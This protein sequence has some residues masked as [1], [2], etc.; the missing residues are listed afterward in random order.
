VYDWSETQSW[1]K[2]WKALMIGNIPD[3]GVARLHCKVCYPAS[4]FA[5]GTELVGSMYPWMQWLEKHVTEENDGKILLNTKALSLVKDG[6]RIVGVKA[7]SFNGMIIHVKGVK[8]VILAGS[9]F[10]NNRNM[11]QKYCPYV[12]KKAVAT[13]LPPTD[14]GETIRMAFGA[15]ADI[16]GRNSWVAFSGAIPFYDTQY[17]GKKEPGPWFQYLRQGFLQLTRGGGWLEINSACEE[18]LPDVAKMDYEMHPKAVAAQDGAAAY[19]VFDDN[20]QKEIWNTLPPPL[21]DDRPMTLDDPEYPW[22]DKFKKFAPKNWVDSVNMAI[23]LGGIKKSDTIEGLAVQLGLDP[24]KLSN[25]IRM[26]NEKSATKKKDAFGRLP[27]NIKPIVKKPYYGIKTGSIIGCIYC[28]PRV[29]YKLEVLDKKLDPIPGLYA[30]GLNAGGTNG[31]G[32]NNPTAL[33]SVGLAYTTGWMAGDNAT[34]PNPTYV[35]HGME[36]EVDIAAQRMLNEINEHFPSLGLFL[37]NMVFKV[38]NIRN[39]YK[40]K[41]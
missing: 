40:P 7:Q 11:I 14:T 8:G 4:A 22:F 26:W 13:F 36:L 20:Y 18:F 10:T 30:V 31:E 16:A 9:G 39:P 12:Y 37:M 23:E 19:V 41:R 24:I 21:F 38:S 27:Y 5:S 34:N 29:N 3:Q 1:G 28:G 32:V 33:S 15:G 17:T 35:P 25:R 2:G 6:D